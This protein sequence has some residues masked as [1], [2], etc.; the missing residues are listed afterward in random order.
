MAE[1][2][3][4]MAVRVFQSSGG[5]RT[6]DAADSARLTV[7]AEPLGAPVFVQASTALPR[8]HS[9]VSSDGSVG[10]QTSVMLRARAADTVTLHL[11]TRCAGGPPS[12]ALSRLWGT[13]TYVVVLR[14]QTWVVVS[15]S[16]VA[17]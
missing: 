13:V 12:S 11:T 6:V 14:D 3:M 5:L 10:G 17:S 16:A 1:Y 15:T 8:C 7:L 4:R 2:E 9:D